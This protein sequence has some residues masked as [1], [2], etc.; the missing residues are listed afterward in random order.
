MYS[1]WHADN[2]FGS[3]PYP[4]APQTLFRKAG[5]EFGGG[6]MTTFLQGPHGREKRILLEPIAADEWALENLG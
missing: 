4:K 3:A 2:N 5:V 6:G 1:R